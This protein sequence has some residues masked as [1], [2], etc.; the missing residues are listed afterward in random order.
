M[1]S[2][3]FMINSSSPSIVTSVPDHLPNKMRS[4]T[5]TSGLTNSPRSSR[6]PGPT[7]RTSPWL[8]FSV[9]E[10]ATARRR[11]PGAADPQL[12]RIGIFIDD[13]FEPSP[14]DR[15]DVRVGDILTAI[16]GHR[17]ASVGAFQRW[18]YLS[19]VGRSIT[20]ELFRDGNTLEK[21]VT[22]EERPAEAVPR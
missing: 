7:D 15:A 18:L 14:A 5:A 11:L 6:A 12:P 21:A 4:P 20:L 10:P 17:I 13:V 22:V 16:D 2:D 9:L 3:S 19:G 8:G 1:I